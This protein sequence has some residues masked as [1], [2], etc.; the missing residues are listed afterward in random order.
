MKRTVYF[1][2]AVLLAAGCGSVSG[3]NAGDGAAGGSSVTAGASGVGG[4][5]GTT[6]AGGASG[7]TSGAGGTGGGGLGG[8]AGGQ[9]GEHRCGP[10]PSCTRCTIGACCGSGCCGAG[11]WC[12][13]SG[14]TPVCRCS[15]NNACPTG[16]MCAS[17]IGGLNICGVV[18]CTG[19]GCPMSRRMFKRDIQSVDDPA[20]QRIYD[21]LREI[22]LT[23][24]A[25][26]VDPKEAKRHLGFIIDDTKT[27][28]PINPDGNT[29]DL[30]GYMSMAVAAIQVQSREIEALRAE[31]AR[32]RRRSER[33]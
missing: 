11:E 22:Q 2:F 30:Y 1:L 18:C 7:G 33:Q 23:T 27:Q 9:G 24:Y 20:L 29:V 5:G 15:S 32:L 31:V 25:Y 28:Y 3:T 8:S 26:K 13:T 14:T 6:G 12:D 19:G 16:E 10:D 17:S 4:R 21:E